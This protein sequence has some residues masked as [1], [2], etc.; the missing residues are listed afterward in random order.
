MGIAQA[1]RNTFQDPQKQSG[2]IAK[3]ILLFASRLNA[4]EEHTKRLTDVIMD[5]RASQRSAP[6][7]ASAAG[8]GDAGV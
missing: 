7:S 6:A 4:G 2:A 8:G 1:A 3:V 5:I